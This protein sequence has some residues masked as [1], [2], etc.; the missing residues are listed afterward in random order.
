MRGLNFGQKLS[1]NLSNSRPGKFYPNLMLFSDQ[2]RISK[3]LLRSRKKN[4]SIC[5]NV[6]QALTR[7]REYEL[8]TTTRFSAY[9]S[10]KGFGNTGIYLHNFTF[11]DFYN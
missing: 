2:I 6:Q 11:K 3:Q 1:N 10:D 5:E 8:R 4:I 9:K 7:L